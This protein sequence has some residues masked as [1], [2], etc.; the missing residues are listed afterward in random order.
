MLEMEKRKKEAKFSSVLIRIR[1]PDGIEIQGRFKGSNKVKILYKFTNEVLKSH[2]K[3]YY[4]YTTPPVKKLDMNASLFDLGLCP[5]AIVYFSF[6]EKSLHKNGDF[7]LK[8]IYDILEDIPIEKPNNNDLM[9][10]KK[11]QVE[12]EEKKSKKIPKMLLNN[13]IKK[14]K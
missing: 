14:K 5:H 7:F 9:N 2:D 12:I 1:F 11:K 8:Q 10:E 4:L 13:L 3:P 6:E